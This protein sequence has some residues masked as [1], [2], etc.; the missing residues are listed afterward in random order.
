MKPR[1][2]FYTNIPSPYNIDF[3]EALTEHFDLGV[4]Y[5][6]SIESDRQWT[7]V[8]DQ[9]RYKRIC[10]ENNLIARLIQKVKSDFHF[11][12]AIFR[13]AFTDDARFVVA[14]GNY[15]LPNTVAVLLI[16]KL[17]GKVILWFGERLFTSRSKLRFLFK[18]MLMLPLR[19]CCKEVLCIGDAAASSY[20][21][22]GVKRPM[23]IVPYNIND[24]RYKKEALDP[25]RLE[26]I[27]AELNPDGKCVVITSGSLIH[28]KGMDVAIE[29]FCTL[30]ELLRQDAELWIMGDG[31][32]RAELEARV[33]GR[34]RVVFL[35]FKEKEEIPYLYGLSDLF[36]FCSRYD[37]WGVVV[38][39]AMSASLPVV[40]SDRVVASQLVVEGKG[41]YVCASDSVADFRAA[42]EKVVRDPALRR[43]MGEFN[44]QQAARWNS[45]SMAA[46]VLEICGKYGQF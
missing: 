43:A 25:V 17:R 1:L 40:L 33:N 39:E 37:G 14:S 4:V 35:G 46:K 11:S 21:A 22:H 24:S 23:E 45:A 38:N 26:R 2:T 6:S 31:E 16:S 29:A 15:Y 12:N 27:R 5:Y 7:L 34:G 8:E 42:L 3:F 10:L 41:G 30:P 44:A 28:R 18:K 36:L 20:R 9:A 19:N 13:Q 32:L